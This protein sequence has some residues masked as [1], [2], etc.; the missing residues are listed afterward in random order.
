MNDDNWIKPTRGNTSKAPRC[1]R[2]NLL[3]LVEHTSYN[4]FIASRKWRP[5]A[6]SVA[7]FAM[8]RL[9]RPPHQARGAK[10]G[11]GNRP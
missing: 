8:C 4:R 2:L 10:A 9:D 7:G 3:W 11:A 5:R 1:T 6:G